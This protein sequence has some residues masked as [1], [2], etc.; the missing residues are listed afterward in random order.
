MLIAKSENPAGFAGWVHAEYSY[1]IIRQRTG[2][3]I[4]GM[5]NDGPTENCMLSDRAKNVSIPIAAI[6]QVIHN[7]NMKKWKKHLSELEGG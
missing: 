1:C 7:V 6:V 2:K 5:A 3:G 4:E